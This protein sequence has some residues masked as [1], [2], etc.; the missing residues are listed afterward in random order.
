MKLSTYKIKKNARA[1]WNRGEDWDGIVTLID[2][3]NAKKTL[4]D[5]LDDLDE[6]YTDPEWLDGAA[7]DPLK[8]DFVFDCNIHDLLWTEPWPYDDFENVATHDAVS[9]AANEYLCRIVIQLEHEAS[10]NPVLY[11]INHGDDRSLLQLLE[12][13]TYSETE[14]ELYEELYRLVE[15][16]IEQDA[17]D[18]NIDLGNDYCSMN[19][20][21]VDWTSIIAKSES[22]YVAEDDEVVDE[23]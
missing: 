4:A 21:M 3:L 13:T 17:H 9:D 22:E 10:D 16:T 15:E 19:D 20:Q 8:A 23:D 7:W 12:S 1:E 2:L 5:L 18:V 11:L 6:D 14:D